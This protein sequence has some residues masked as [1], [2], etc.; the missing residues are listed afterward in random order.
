M[1]Y[2]RIRDLREDRDLTQSQVAQMLGIGQRAY[3]YYESGS[4]ML[5][6]EILCALAKIYQVSTD[7]LLG[8]TDD[9]K[10]YP[11]GNAKP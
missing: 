10:P 8:L 11:A 7:Y 3:A 5:P 9:K 1:R 4:R 2:Q 6:P